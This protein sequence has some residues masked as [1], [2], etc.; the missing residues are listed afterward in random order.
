MSI[1]FA[2]RCTAE[3]A[4]LICSSKGCI[5]LSASSLSSQ[6]TPRLIPSSKQKS[7]NSNPKRSVAL[8]SRSLYSNNISSIAKYANRR[9]KVT[10]EVKWLTQARWRRR[11]IGAP[12]IVH[13]ARWPILIGKACSNTW[14]N[15][16]ECPVFARYA[17]LTHTE[18]LAT[19]QEICM[20]T[21]SCVI[22]SKWVKWLKTRKATRPCCSKLCLNR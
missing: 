9:C 8:T 5:V 3:T 20:P 6:R 21:C 1:A 13:F 12:S 19:S 7:V 18:T 4:W 15:T 17:S 16:A 2:N 11:L 10:L 22:N 14:A